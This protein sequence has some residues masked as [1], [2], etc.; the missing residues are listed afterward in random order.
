MHRIHTYPA[1]FPSFITIKALEY[2]REKVNVATVGDIF[3]VA[4]LLHMKLQSKDMIFGDVM[5]IP[6]H[7]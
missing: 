2:A 6:L 5:S 4:V 3:A 7:R 1:K